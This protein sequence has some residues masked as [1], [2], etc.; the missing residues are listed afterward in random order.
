MADSFQ[1]LFGG[2]A[3]DAA[4]YDQLGTLD[5]EEHADLPGALEM[6]M[7]VATQGSSGSEDL[8]AVGD[9][10]WKPYAHV[11]VVATPDGKTG[12][13]IF[14]GYVLSHKLHVDRGTTAS[15]LRV[16]AQDATCLMNVKERA[17]SWDGHTDGSVANTIFQAYGITGANGNTQNDSATHK[18]DTLR[19]VQRAT[20]AQF[21]RDRARRTGKLFRVACEDQP[22]QPKGYFVKPSL[23]GTPVVTLTLNPTDAANV[24]AL[25]VEWDVARPAHTLAKA[26]L[27]QKDA[28]NGDTQ[29]SGLTSLDQRTLAQFIDHDDY[30]MEARL[31][32][33]VDSAGELTERA[34]ALL[35]EGG[36]F[37]RCEG[38]ADLSRLNWVLRVGTVVRVNGAGRVHSGKYFVWSVRHSIDARAHRMK[39]VLVRNAVGA[40]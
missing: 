32:T 4:F 39:F 22:G 3:A 20:D 38:E 37:V 27:D 10:R 1:V 12:A 25:E 31:T 18:D 29:D 17:K 28:E 34:A 14:D 13:C 16:W 40:A 26:L 21:L 23:D 2:R 33:A 5:V 8:T 7:P 35:R 24:D 6:T 30:V 19:L 11:A 36:W 15:T 9:A